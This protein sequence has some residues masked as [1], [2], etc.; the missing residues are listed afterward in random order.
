MDNDSQGTASTGEEASHNARQLRVRYSFKNA[1]FEAEGTPEDVNRHAMAF[2]SVVTRRKSS[3]NEAA[4]PYQRSLFEE[5]DVPLFADNGTPETANHNGGRSHG[6]DDLLSFYLKKTLNPNTETCDATQSEQLLIITYYLE[7]YEHR[8]HVVLADYRNAYST[9]SKVPV[10][11]PRN[12]SAR[13]G[14]LVKDGLLRRV[15]GGYALT[16]RGKPAVEKIG[17][18]N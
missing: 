6:D 17:R 13:L 4:S 11:E 12:I 16:L 14:E 2:L 3:S 8:E 1:E 15:A 10:S 5:S 7:E 9:L 18:S